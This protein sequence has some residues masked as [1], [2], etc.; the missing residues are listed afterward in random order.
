MD[1]SAEA[2]RNSI[3][4]ELIEADDP[5]SASSLAAAYSVSRQIIV[6]DIAI[7]RASGHDIL[8]TP[9]G[10]IYDSVETPDHKYEELIACNHT[11]DDMREEL[12][13]IVDNGATAID[14]TVE[15]LVYGQLSGNLDLSSRYDVDTFISKFDEAEDIVPM[16][17]LTQGAHLHRIGASSKTVLERVKSALKEK[18]FLIE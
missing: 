13:T 16:S 5:K 18:G 1:L 14:V 17:V 6:G 9:K 8:A 7:L 12:Y 4:K 10:Y 11:A 3:L 2:R 15:H